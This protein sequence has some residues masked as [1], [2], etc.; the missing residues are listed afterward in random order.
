MP[1]QD[2]PRA[3]AKRPRRLDELPLAQRQHL[4]AHDARHRQPRHRAQAGVEQQ[5]PRRLAAAAAERRLQPALQHPLQR[6]DD[7]DYKNDRRQR[8]EHVHRAHHQVVPAPAEQ[9]GRRTPQHADHQAHQR[10]DQADDQRNPRAGQ[11]APEQVAPV[12]VGAKPMPG[13]WRGELR[14]AVHIALAR[15]Q[16]P[17]QRQHEQAK[18]KHRRHHRRTVVAEPQPGA[19]V[20]RLAGFLRL[21][22]RLAGLMRCLSH[23]SPACPASRRRHRPPSSASATS[24]NIK[25]PARPPSCS[26]G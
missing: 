12:H 9:A 6:R 19:A 15:D 2:R 22:K 18:Q 24:R 5:H 1:P 26:R 4:P 11:H 25:S 16:R 7:H 20:R 10:A 13:A 17:S 3:E 23:I 8:V 21:A 14:L